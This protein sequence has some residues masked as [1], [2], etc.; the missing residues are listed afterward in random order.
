MLNF[1]LFLFLWKREFEQGKEK[2]SVNIPIPIY[3]TVCKFG[4]VF[5]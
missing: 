5:L 1:E 3:K 2:N 4:Y